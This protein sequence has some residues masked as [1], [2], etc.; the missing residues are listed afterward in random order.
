MR[1]LA[2]VW[3]LITVL[4]LFFVG[5]SVEENRYRIAVRLLVAW[6]LIG[7]VSCLAVLWMMP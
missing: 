2:I 1:A 7:I 3:G 5:W 6:V 4:V